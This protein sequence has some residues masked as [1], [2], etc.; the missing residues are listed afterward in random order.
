M[1]PYGFNSI[2]KHGAGVRLLP[3]LPGRT[4]V[5]RPLARG[6]IRKE[7]PRRDGRGAFCVRQAETSGDRPFWMAQTAAW[8]RFWALIFR[9]TFLK[10]IFTV[11]S[12]M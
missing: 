10:C 8:V 2:G 9:I 4:P 3:E 6:G 1:M 12:V 7:A 5:A 11:D